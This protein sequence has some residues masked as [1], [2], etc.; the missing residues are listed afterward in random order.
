MRK[1]TWHA[2][3]GVRN[4]WHSTALFVGNSGTIRLRLAARRT[5]TPCCGVPPALALAEISPGR[6]LVSTALRVHWPTWE[7]TASHFSL[8]RKSRRQ[9]VDPDVE[10]AHHCHPGMRANPAQHKDTSKNE[11]K[12]FDPRDPSTVS[13][14]DEL[15]DPSLVNRGGQWWLYLAGQQHGYGAPD[16]Y[17]ASLAP[18]APLSPHGWEISRGISGQLAAVAGRSLSSEWD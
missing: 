8:P 7:L 11:I 17:S 15:L 6:E 14:G 10:L 9:P 5:S 16:I 1:G 18:G 12:I 13:S 2:S 3:I 4:I